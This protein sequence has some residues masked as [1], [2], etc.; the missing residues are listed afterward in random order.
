[1]KKYLENVVH[2][3]GRKIKRSEEKEFHQNLIEYFDMEI[4]KERLKRYKKEMEDAYFNKK[5]YRPEN[6]ITTN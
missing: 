1:M 5:K 2:R 4:E 3:I 6:K